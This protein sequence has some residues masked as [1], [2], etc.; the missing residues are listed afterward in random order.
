MADKASKR[1]GLY[2][3]VAALARQCGSLYRNVRSCKDDLLGFMEAN[4]WFGQEALGGEEDI[5]MERM[6]DIEERLLLWLRAY[7]RSPKEKT[8]ILLEAARIRYPKTCGLY[9]DFLV[10]NEIYGTEGS[11]RVLDYL[12]SSIDRELTLYTEDDLQ[13]VFQGADA[14]LTATQMRLLFDFLD[15]LKGSGLRLKYH[16]EP[17]ARRLARGGNPAYTLEQFARMAFWTFNADSWKERS[18]VEKASSCK[19]FAALWLYI[20]LH[21]V[22]AWRTSDMLRLPFPELPCPGDETRRRVAAGEFS[23]SEARAL[24]REWTFLVDTLSMTPGKTAAHGGA[25]TLKILI[26]ETLE[27][28]FGIILALAASYREENG[29]LVSPYCDSRVLKRFFGAEFLEAAGGKSFLNRRA[30]KAFLQ[31]VEENAVN[32]PGKPAG[33]MLAAL[34][35]SHKGG[36]DSLP[37][38]TDIYLQ[39]ANFTGYKPEFILREMFERGIFGF[40][41]ALLLELY[42]GE[43][44]RK[45]PVSSQTELIRCVGLPPQEIE[46][47]TSAVGHTLRKAERLVRETVST[48]GDSKESLSSLLQKIALGSIP[49]K[50]T[51]LLCL[52]MAAGMTCACVDRSG[53][54]GC[55]YEIYTKAALQIL[56]RDYVSLSRRRACAD[57]W[58]KE[59]FRKLMEDGILPS[60]T[61]IMTSVPMLYPDADMA[62]ML[63]LLERGIAHAAAPEY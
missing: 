39:D 41:P 18:L 12:I 34:A 51:E 63:E 28:P 2:A 52:R 61:E 15:G 44:Y 53:C 31:G 24:T 22:C 57:G 7:R 58:E 30:N 60:V 40:I 47:I 14:F 32:S 1:S 46:K 49:A 10:Q 59:R 55:G 20:A 45:L 5:R 33:Y 62:P 23:D 48:L 43:R 4:E 42:A 38:I 3:R 54:I 19:T 35:R 11:L 13:G 50:Q 56:M 8:D 36:V 6:E 17:K 16:Y 9:L 21:F 26:P 37:N 27:K 25:P 29:R